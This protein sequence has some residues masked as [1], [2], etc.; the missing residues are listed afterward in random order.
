MFGDVGVG[1]AR[2]LSGGGGGGAVVSEEGGASIANNNAEICAAIDLSGSKTPPPPRRRRRPR[3]KSGFSR[4]ASIAQ[5]F[6]GAG[7]ISGHGAGIFLGPDDDDDLVRTPILPVNEQYS[8]SQLENLYVDLLSTIDFQFGVSTSEALHVDG[9][10]PDKTT[11]R[12]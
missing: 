2:D 9:G 8:R 6:A 3:A 11:R 7:E 10:K 4:P 1:G 5:Q 12:R